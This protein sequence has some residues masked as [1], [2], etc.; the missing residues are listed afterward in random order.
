MNK[1]KIRRLGRAPKKIRKHPRGD[2]VKLKDGL[3]IMG[4]Y[5]YVPRVMYAKPVT[6]GGV[7]SPAEADKPA[8]TAR[9]RQWTDFPFVS[10]SDGRLC[11]S[12][13]EKN[14]IF[15]PCYH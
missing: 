4:S 1:N 5:V 3:F 10:E 13:R 2:G 14:T 9:R 11:A 6:V 12:R 15:D 8:D 7:H